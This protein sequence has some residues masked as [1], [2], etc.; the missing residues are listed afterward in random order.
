ML[1]GEEVSVFCRRIGP[2]VAIAWEPDDA[3]PAMRGL[4]FGQHRAGVLAQALLDRLAADS[5]AA[6]PEV[7]SCLVEPCLSGPAVMA[8]RATP[9]GLESRV[10]G[11]PARCRGTCRGTRLYAT[12]PPGTDIW[13]FVSNT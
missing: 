11:S 3:R 1:R 7:G 4:S 2:G 6:H 12:G 13:L 8:L 10:A 9:T 5:D